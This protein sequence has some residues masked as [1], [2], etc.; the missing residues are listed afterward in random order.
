MKFKIGD[1]IQSIEYPQVV[2]E[3]VDMNDTQYKYIVLKTDE[4]KFIGE[5]RE[6]TF[7]EVDP[8]AK[9]YCQCDIRDL[10]IKGCQCVK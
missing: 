3:I 1:K 9:L 7:D 5:H 8:Y 10:A 6:S 4:E 2:V